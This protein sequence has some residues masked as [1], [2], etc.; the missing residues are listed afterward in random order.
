MRKVAIARHSKTAWNAACKIIGQEDIPL[1]AEGRIQSAALGRTLQGSPE[2][3]I[4]HIVTSDLSRA[5]ETSCTVAQALGLSR[6]RIR[7][8]ARFREANLGR[9]QGKTAAE[10]ASTHG[11]GILRPPFDFTP[12]G[13]ETHE[14]VVER[15]V[16][17]MHD[18]AR[19][20][21]PSGTIA[22]VLVVSHSWAIEAYLRHLLGER[23][24]LGNA[25]WRILTLQDPPP[26]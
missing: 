13:G 14:E 11:Q 24:Q 20:S 5:A 7:K 1:I 26:P 2:V 23:V 16:S 21:D 8:D 4:E 9:L 12:F 10:I 25:E 6:A 17:G 3:R 19:L 15:M 18:V 22:T